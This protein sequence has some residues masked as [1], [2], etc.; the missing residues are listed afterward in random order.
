MIFSISENFAMEQVRTLKFVVNCSPFLL[1]SYNSKNFCDFI[2]VSK[3]QEKTF[4]SRARNQIIVFDIKGVVHTLNQQHEVTCLA[5]DD[6]SET[7]FSGDVDGNISI[8]DK[9][10]KFDKLGVKKLDRNPVQ[11]LLVKKQFLISSHLY[12]LVQFNIE[13]RTIVKKFQMNSTCIP[14]FAGDAVDKLFCLD[15]K[16][17]TLCQVNLKQNEGFL[18]S[19]MSNER[20]EVE[21]R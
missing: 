2:M 17:K 5:Y 11:S 20:S 12:H 21:K 6:N 10:N 16:R 3:T 8:W 7:L 9:K 4:K 19:E 18:R 15:Q 14:I 1:E 13:Y